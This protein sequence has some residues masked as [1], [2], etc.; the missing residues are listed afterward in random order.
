VLLLG[1]AL[2]LITTL[3]HYRRRHRAAR[4][5]ELARGRRIIVELPTDP[6]LTLFSS[7]ETHF[8]HGAQ[9]IPKDRIGAV[10]VLING[11][12]IA[13]AVSVRRASAEVGQPTSF[14]DRPEGI[15]R[16]RWDVAIETQDGTVLVECGAV[17]ERVSQELARKIFDAV[18]EAV[19]D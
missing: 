4:D 19:N 8:Y 18:K 6:E 12:P 10:R 17:R 16:D 7:D 2:S 14:E 1:L 3:H 15:A 13:A 9:A 11:S 5:V